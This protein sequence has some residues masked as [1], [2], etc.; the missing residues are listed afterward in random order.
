MSLMPEIL[1]SREFNVDAWCLEDHSNVAA[2]TVRVTGDVEPHN[3]GAPANRNHESGKYAKQRGFSAAI[4]PQQSEE[5]GPT[6][7]EGDAIQRSS[8]TITMHDIAH[9]NNDW[10]DSEIGLRSVNCEWSFE[11]HRLFYDETLSSGLSSY[12]FSSSPRDSLFE[13]RRHLPPHLN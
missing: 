9:G 1:S 12:R 6:H 13:R 3:L 10:L 4:R 8:V 7:I 5:F 11:S 2:K